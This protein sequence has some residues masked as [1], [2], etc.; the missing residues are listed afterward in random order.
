MVLLANIV[1]ARV[2]DADAKAGVGIY[3]SIYHCI[4]VITIN[5]II[6]T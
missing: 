6:K 5:L 3:F 2:K 4:I 1:Y